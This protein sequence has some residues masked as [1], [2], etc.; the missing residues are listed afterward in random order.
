MP[1][2]SNLDNPEYAAHAWGR[3]WRLMRWMA[4]ITSIAIVIALVI[5]YSIN[6]WVSIHLYIAAGLGI[7][8]SMLLTAG[9]M[10]LVFLSSGTGHDDSI[11]DP[12]ADDEDLK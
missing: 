4:A 5:L 3:Y 7:G 12:L 10:G 11:D 9:L 1:K 8:V 6:G 2:V